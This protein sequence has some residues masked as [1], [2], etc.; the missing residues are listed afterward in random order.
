VRVWGRTHER[1]Q[2]LVQVLSGRPDA[3]GTTFR[4]CAKA[5]EAVYE[6]D[7]ICTVTFATTPVI[8]RDW[9]KPGAHINGESTLLSLLS[10]S[11]G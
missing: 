1:A 7:V 6:A 11:F 5:E 3:A 2:K 4:A 9:V 10:L 8:F